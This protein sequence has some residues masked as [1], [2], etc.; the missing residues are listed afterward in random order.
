MRTYR[1][2]SQSQLISNAIRGLLED[3]LTGAL[4]TLMDSPKAES[5]NARVGAKLLVNES[6]DKVGCADHEPPIGKHAKFRLVER[7]ES[8]IGIGDEVDGAQA[9]AAAGYTVANRMDMGPTSELTA[10]R[11]QGQA[12]QIVATQAG[13]ATRV[14]VTFGLHQ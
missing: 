11:G 2:E 14:Q 12:I 6:G 1:T 10:Q 5:N 4:A 8:R 7:R 9:V 3:G 13:D